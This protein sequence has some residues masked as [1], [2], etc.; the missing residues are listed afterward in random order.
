M[1][2]EEFKGELF[3]IIMQQEEVKG[4]K[5]MLL[6]KGFTTR[7]A[8]MLS[9][10]RYI[11]K[12]TYGREDNVVRADYI[13]VVWG[14]GSIRSM[15]NWGVREYFEKYK[16]NGWEGVLPELLIKIQNAGHSLEWLHLEAEGYELC[17]HRLIIRPINYERNKYELESCIYWQYGDIALTLYGI[18]SDEEDDY[19]TMKISHH[20]IE[21]WN[22]SD[23]ALL[24]N[25]MRNTCALMPPRLYYCTDLRRKHDPEEGIFMPEEKMESERVK[26]DRCLND[27][28]DFSPFQ[29]HLD[30]ELEG[31]LGY[32][33]ST[34][35]GINGAVALF[36][37]G[38]Q[39]RLAQM[40]GGDY[41]VGFTSIHEA[42][43]HP[44][45]RQQPLNMKESIH[46]IN[47]V[48]PWDEMLSNRVFRYYSER[49]ELVEV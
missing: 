30:N 9:M 38:V 29:V 2:Y 39:E 28:E 37:P 22:I 40:M 49:R 20:L 36:Y 31:S 4:K 15:M 25:A 45:S 44:V 47:E 42:I 27:E 1:N 23:E 13:H 35:K 19:V 8:Q 41:L 11:N 18:V 14:E 7:D 46:D 32:R 12:V 43:I 33:L 10:I 24:T 21:E 6:E 34:T 48:F 26:K 5:V 17:R 16:K 3:R